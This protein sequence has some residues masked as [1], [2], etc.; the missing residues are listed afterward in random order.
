MSFAVH[1]GSWC[2]SSI[3]VET[4]GNANAKM[5][6]KLAGNQARAVEKSRAEWRSRAEQSEQRVQ[7]LAR[8]LAELKKE[9][10]CSG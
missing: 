1:C 4:T 6:C 8:E 2:G 9:Q 3:A 10:C 7:E 5:Q